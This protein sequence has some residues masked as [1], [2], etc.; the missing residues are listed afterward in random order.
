M[1]P[2]PKITAQINQV[3]PKGSQKASRVLII[4]R[5]QFRVAFGFIFC[6]ILMVLDPFYVDFG[7]D[8]GQYLIDFGIDFKGFGI[9][10]VSK[11]PSRQRRQTQNARL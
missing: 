9:D 11:F 6:Q 5:S 8:F 3:A 1:Q 7:A 2:G 10:C 4:W